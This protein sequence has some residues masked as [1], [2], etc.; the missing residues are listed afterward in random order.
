MT[1]AYWGPLRASHSYLCFKPFPPPLEHSCEARTGPPR[2]SAVSYALAL[3]SMASRLFILLSPVV[4]TS[5]LQ[6]FQLLSAVNFPPE[7]IY[8]PG[9]QAHHSPMPQTHLEGVRATVY[10][11]A[12]VSKTNNSSSITTRD[13][14]GRN[15]TSHIEPT[16]RSPDPCPPLESPSL[17][18]VILPSKQTLTNET[19][20][21]FY[22]APLDSLPTV[23]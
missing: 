19:V 12:A 9:E 6:T 3:P 1:V 16:H 13:N 10:L 15:N 2:P 21:L 18:L 11:D 5:F 20:P 23:K 17:S 14:Q 7:I 22:I 4:C 8:L